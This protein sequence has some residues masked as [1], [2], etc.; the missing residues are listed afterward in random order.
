[1]TSES[2]NIIRVKLLK[3]PRYGLG[4]LIRHRSKSPHV[5]VSDLVSGGMAAQSGLV[6]IGDLI[7]KVN[8]T[9]LVDKSYDE[10]L[11]I[12]KS[13]PIN[14]PVVIVLRGPEG[15]TS[16]LETRFQNDGTPRTIR[17]TKPVLSQDSFMDRIKKT[18][19]GSASP[20][21]CRSKQTQANCFC[22]TNNPTSCSHDQH[23]NKQSVV[24]KTTNPCSFSVQGQNE[25]HI[26]ATTHLQRDESNGVVVKHD[27]KNYNQHRNQPE[28]SLT[29]TLLN[30]TQFINTLNESNDAELKKDGCTTNESVGAKTI[31]SDNV[32]VDITRGELIGEQGD[33][34]D[35]CSG[36]KTS[37]PNGPL[38][39]PAIVSTEVSDISRQSGGERYRGSDSQ[40]SAKMPLQNG[41]NNNNN[42]NQSVNW[43]GDV[44]HAISDGK[45]V[46]QSKKALE[47]NRQPRTRESS[48]S[49]K[50]VRL[51]CVGEE[52][53]VCTDT[54]HTKAKEVS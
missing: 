9:D 33:M 10:S 11:E 41:N 37:L 49:R 1:M 52:R 13:L 31:V 51:R 3:Q 28:M 50:F 47:V 32:K 30:S 36:I 7:L 42:N 35:K 34:N 26:S 48:P 43:N 27:H 17:V 14:S 25:P 18:F 46:N 20:K 39:S 15:Y 22:T 53:P 19:A 16:H 23:A 12:L 45:V 8:D 40:S 6:Q 44:S 4:F 38:N 29:S 24:N 54:L 21:P 5:V 2:S